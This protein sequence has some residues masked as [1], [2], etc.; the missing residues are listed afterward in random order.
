MLDLTLGKT[1]DKVAVALVRPAHTSNRAILS[2]LVADGLF[3]APFSTE[4]VDEDDVVR[5]S[6]C[7][8]LVVG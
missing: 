8:L 1:N 5:L 6:D 4:L 2:E 3:L 7:Q